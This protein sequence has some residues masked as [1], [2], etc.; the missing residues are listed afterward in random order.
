MTTRDYFRCYGLQN[1]ERR[2]SSDYQKRLDLLQRSISLWMAVYDHSYMKRE[3]KKKKCILLDVLLE[4]EWMACEL[5]CEAATVAK[6][7][8]LVVAM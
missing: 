2:I 3:K 5:L 4:V 8:A 7:P 6:L 1:R